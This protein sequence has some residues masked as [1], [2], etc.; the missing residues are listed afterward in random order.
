MKTPVLIIFICVASFTAKSQHYYRD[1]VATREIVQKRAMYLQAKVRSVEYASFDANN[2]PIDGFS[3]EQTVSADYTSISTVTTTSLTGS[4]E[5]TSLFNSAGQ[6]TQTLD[7]SDGNKVSV[8][9]VYDA[10][11]KMVD[12]VSESTSPGQYYSKEEH[13]WTYNNT[14]KP[15]SMLKIKNG[16]DTT[17]VTIIPDEKGNVGEEKSL[18]H[19]SR[20][21]SVYYYY[22]DKNRLTDIVRFNEVAKRLLPD[23]IFEYDAQ[24]R[25][26]TMLVTTG[27]GTDYQKWYYTY[28]DKGLKAKDECY[29]K[30]KVLIG[31][32]EYRYQ[33]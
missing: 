31:K 30:T 7:T 6:L 1:L 26:A 11:G 29:S 18:H 24:N 8:T 4:T 21:P 33:F 5:N 25:F 20:E 22:D 23:Y 9:Y 13:I 27:G 12:L 19:G 17:F 32:V 16:T 14:G 28:N 10:N 2:Q 15:V 3:C